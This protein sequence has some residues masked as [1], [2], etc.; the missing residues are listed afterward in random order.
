M[1]QR[2]RITARLTVACLVMM[3][4]CAEKSPSASP[5]P[6]PAQSIANVS[7]GNN[8]LQVM[9]VRLPAGRGATT[10]VVVFIHGGGWEGGDKAVFTTADLEKFTARGYAT[11]NMNYRLSTIQFSLCKCVRSAVHSL[12]GRGRS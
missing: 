1:R 9:D 8:V 2:G 10:G 7:Y 3:W 4:G 11:V 12:Q 6:L 5:T